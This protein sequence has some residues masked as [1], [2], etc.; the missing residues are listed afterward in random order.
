[1]TGP[2]IACLFTPHMSAKLG[3]KFANVSFTARNGVL[4]LVNWLYGGGDDFHSALIGTT[5]KKELPDYRKGRK[6]PRRI[7]VFCYLPYQ[8]ENLMLDKIGCWQNL[9][10]TLRRPRHW[11]YK[12]L[13]SSQP[14]LGS[15][16]H[17]T[18]QYGKILESYAIAM[19]N[20]TLH[21]GAELVHIRI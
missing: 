15:W 1:M 6:I 16:I 17:K 9:C 13:G 2:I 21:A 10:W 14:I 8:N 18:L 20:N 12:M 11:K 4:L 19:N 7:F 3:I 5:D